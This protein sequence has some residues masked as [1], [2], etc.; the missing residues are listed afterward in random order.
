MGMTLIRG[1]GHFDGGTMCHWPDGADGK[2]ALLTGDIVQVVA[3]RRW[4]SFMYSYP[5]LIPLSAAKV[6]RIVQSVEP[7]AFDRLY[8]AWWERIVFEDAKA[9]VHRSATRYIKAIQDEGD[10]VPSVHTTIDKIR[11]SQ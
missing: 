7:F 11:L 9:A 6:K 2:G 5:N 1:G 4:V 8:A 3:D 10:C